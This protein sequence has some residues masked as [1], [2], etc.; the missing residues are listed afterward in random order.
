MCSKRPLLCNYKP[1]CQGRARSDEDLLHIKGEVSSEPLTMLD[2][3]PSLSGDAS[4]TVSFISASFY[5]Y[6]QIIL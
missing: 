4:E 5:Q 6:G 1:E 2:V 3:L